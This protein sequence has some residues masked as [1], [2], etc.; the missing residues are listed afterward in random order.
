M[1]T[2][3]RIAI[4]IAWICATLSDEMVDSGH[5]DVLRLSKRGLLRLSKKDNQDEGRIMLDPPLKRGV[6]RLSKRD[7]ATRMARGSLDIPPNL[8]HLTQRSLR[9]SKRSVRDD[10]VNTELAQGHKMVIRLSKRQMAHLLSLK[11]GSPTTD[12]RLS[13][14]TRL[15]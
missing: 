1:G 2:W 6:L 9:L 7:P 8:L 13:R 15:Q 12:L 3:T 10:Q 5:R 11:S 4:F 14:Y